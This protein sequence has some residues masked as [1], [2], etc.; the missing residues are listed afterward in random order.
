MSIAQIIFMAVKLFYMLLQRWLHFIIHLFKPI[1][2]IMARV[3]PNM[4][5]GFGD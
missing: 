3:K 2:S 4:N 1:E 5:Y